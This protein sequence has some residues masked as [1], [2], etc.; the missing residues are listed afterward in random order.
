VSIRSQR[1]PAMRY[2]PARRTDVETLAEL[3]LLAYRVSSLEKRRDFYTDHPRFGLRDVRVGELDGQLVA[4]LVLYPLTAWVRGQRV[5]LTGVGSVAVS[6]EHRRRGLGETL[7]RAALREMRQ[8]G[9]ALSAL[10]AFRGSYYRKLG[11]GVIEVVQQLAV[12]PANLPA[13]DEARR[14]RR[15]LLPD[16]PAVEALYER[17]AMQGHFA[18]ERSREWWAQRLWGYPGDWVVYEGRRRGQIEG[19]LHYEVDTT[20]GPFRLGLT[21]TEFLAA[22]PEAHRGL[23]GYLA[24]LAD[25][26]AE[27]HHAAPADSL[28]LATLKTAQ[29]L[30]PGPEIGVLLDTGGVAH[31]A[32]LRVTDVKAGLERLPVAPH[33]RGEV[34]LDVDDPVLPHNSRPWRVVARDGRLHVRPAAARAAAHAS[35]AGAQAPQAGRPRRAPAANGAHLKVPADLLG[36]LLAGTLSATGAAAAGLIESS[37]GAEVVESWFRAKPAFLYPM[38]VF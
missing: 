21:L 2:R 6:P 4:S 30:R 25:Q 22:T 26:V 36:P 32:M 10:Y 27:I 19:Y 7:M 37:G 28:W 11:Y 38:N 16:R 23:V 15:L 17:V 9:S 24:S 34:V 3:G 18:L 13:S 29:N 8:R 1:P 31:G 20:H 14:V 5:P 12:A 33:A 35:Q